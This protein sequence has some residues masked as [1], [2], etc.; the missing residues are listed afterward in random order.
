MSNALNKAEFVKLL[1]ER[2]GATKA[3]TGRFVDDFWEVL[4]EQ[5]ENGNDV[6]F[7]GIASFKVADQPSREARNP[8]TGEKVIIPAGKRGSFKF[9]AKFKARVKKSS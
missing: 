5:A 9:G 6:N 3:E 7:I 1:A 4:M 2:N 8:R